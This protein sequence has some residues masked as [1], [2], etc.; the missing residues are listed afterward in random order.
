[1]IGRATILFACF[2]VGAG[3]IARASHSEPTPIRQSFALFPITLGEWRGIAD[4]PFDS[5]TLAVLGADDYL[6]RTYFR[7]IN[8]GAR[9]GSGRYG[10]GLY[11]G[12]YRSQRQGDTI[13]S[14]LNCLPGSGWEP[15]SK[16]TLRISVTPRPG[17]PALDVDVN[18]FVIEKGLERDVVLYWYQ[19]HGRVVASEYVSK[20][21]L[22]RDAVLLNRSDGALVRVIAPV[23][24]RENDGEA[25]AE[26]EARTFVQTMF[27][28]LADFLPE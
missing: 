2:L 27:P 12:Y 11:L 18:R 20:L 17:A 10:V 14:P 3:V 19:S 16:S 5:R 15:V 24:Q 7:S 8:R 26:G 21:F 13:H 9:A 4:P 22:V 1:M 28:R 23:P 25:W 6:A